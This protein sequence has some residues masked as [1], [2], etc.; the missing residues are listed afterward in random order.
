MEQARESEQYLNNPELSARPKMRLLLYPTPYMAMVVDLSVRTRYVPM[1]DVNESPPW[2]TDC[3]DAVV[4]LAVANHLRG[5]VSPKA[6]LNRADVLG[7]YAAMRDMLIK[8]DNQI[9]S[10]LRSP[11]PSRSMVQRAVNASYLDGSPL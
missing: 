6:G 5:G 4:T 9:K 3:D 8:E 10:V 11:L 2:P 7:E 1:Q